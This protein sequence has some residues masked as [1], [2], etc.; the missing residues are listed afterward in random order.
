MSI[1]QRAVQQPDFLLGHIIV[2]RYMPL[3]DFEFM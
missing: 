1:Q 3:L 2:S